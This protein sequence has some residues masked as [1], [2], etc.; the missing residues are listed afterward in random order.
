MLNIQKQNDSSFYFGKLTN[1]LRISVLFISLFLFI[2]TSQA[3]AI[4]QNELIDLKLNN[5]TIIEA[6]KAVEKQTNYK[7]VYNNNDVDVSQKVTLN[8]INESIE[9]VAKII[10][11]GY[12]IAVRGNN[13]IVTRKASSGSNMN[14]MQQPTRRNV[15]GQVIDANTQ[16]TVIGANIWIRES[17]RGTVT[18]IDGNFSIP[19]TDNSTV[20][21]ISFIG[22]NDLTVEVGNRTDLGIIKLT[23][24]EQ[25]LDEVV[26]VGYG[27]QT[28][29]SVIGAISTISVDELK[30]PSSKIS[31]I[32]AGRLAGVVSVTRSGEPGA[33]SEF[34]IRGISTFGANKNPL[35][36]VDGIERSLDLVDPEDIESFSVLKDATATAVYGVRGANGV[37][38]ITT[39]SGKEGR[40]RINLRVEQG[41]TGPT[42][43]P[44]MANSVQFGEMYNEASNSSYYTADVLEKYR[45]GSD[46]DL[47]P[48]VNWIESL[49]ND[50]A[51]NTRANINI[52]GGGSLARYYIAG[53]LYEEGSIFKTEQENTYDSSLK[54]RKINFRS[55][56]DLNLSSSTILNVNLANVY[57]T[58]RRPGHSMSDIWYYAFATS[59]NAFPDRYSDGR[60]SGP[61]SGSGYNP[62][63][64][65]M[66]SG[67]A[68]D[69]WNSAQSLIGITQDFSEMITPGLKA[70]IK[71]SWDAYNS[72]T[73]TRG[74]NPQ[75][76]L[77]TGRNED[78]EIE[79]N[80]T[81]RGGE[82][83]GYDRSLDGRR[84]YYL[85]GSVNYDKV[86]A[87]KHRLGA[88]LLYNQKQ[89]NL[90]NAGDG[91]GSLPY[92]TQGI[93]G[94]VTYSLDDT[95]F[96]EF[97][98]GYNGSENF[99]RGH[100]FGFFPAGALG[101]LV[102]NEEFWEPIN[103]IVDVFKLKSSYGLVG[104]D[105]IGGGRRFIYEETI[106]SEGN[107]YSF[108]STGQ[109]AP[110]R[111]R[112]GEPS[113][114]MVSWEKAYKFNLGAE[115]SLFN[116]L[117]IE[118][119]Y[120]HEKREGIF[121]Q[122]AGL[123]GLVGLSTTPWVNVGK[124][125]NQGFDASLQFNRKI[126]EVHLSALGNFTYS[127]NIIV[128]NDEPD[129]NYKYRNRIDKPFGQPFGLI[130]LG[131]FESQE[132]I[133]NSPRQD[134][135]T[136][137]PGDIKYLD[138]N[139]DGVVD[140]SDEIAI[141]Y[142][143]TPQIN[144]GFGLNAQYR[145]FDA[146]VFFQGIGRTSLFVSGGSIYGFT[147]GSLTRAA[148]NEDVYYKR[149][150]ENNPDPN[151]KYP[152]LDQQNNQNNNRNSTYRMHD[153]SFLRLKNAEL[154]YTI[155]RNITESFY[156]SNLRIYLSAINLLTFSKFNLWD[157]ERGGGEGAAY[158]PNRMFTVG[159]N[160][161]F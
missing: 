96:A 68:N 32:L 21:I 141:G 31:N 60:F 105:Q 120:F 93:A 1:Y 57:E 35:V 119:D 99:A 142:P 118:G 121:M 20:L 125:E 128:D 26:V 158:P 72:G 67:Y 92:R 89:T 156:V 14:M 54:Y 70:N 123:A 59:P 136:V 6:V 102:S 52:S 100:R 117:R 140:V 45:T 80:E 73:I 77:A 147:S 22:Y 139:G 86:Y 87:G 113:N 106:V 16:E 97:N 134:F 155:P 94:R 61:Q 25:T 71:F 132:E 44:K 37:I 34:Y 15:V 107:N 150:T 47:Y 143:S 84:T 157:P 18:D 133:D 103:H 58:R 161:Y 83:L 126:N 46:P 91:L 28:K 24:S 74:F 81:N 48:N 27:T 19:V 116:S 51:H 30:V 95:Y 104:N 151:A 38:I 62:Y 154:G 8:A 144:Y 129:W 111:I 75:Q 159:L 131:L 115:I 29:E 130:A 53:S 50:F 12:H 39:R 43:L 114:T 108:G 76:W 4:A 2:M 98:M 23:P 56:I 88:L 145:G 109:Y 36:L 124:M 101:Y 69:Y 78:G 138:V 135:G 5:T 152:R 9:D 90:L 7:F 40:P 11:A 122:R 55:N 10:F 3:K 42:Q 148:I 82:A 65:L 112:M 146:S 49:Y 127:Q 13:V 33:G 66:Q 110:G 85:E 63:N 149:W 137:R 64:L 17:S 160:I 79:Y 153:A 41:M